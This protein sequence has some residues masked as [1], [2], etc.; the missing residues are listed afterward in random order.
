MITL[1]IILMIAFSVYVGYVTFSAYCLPFGKPHTPSIS[2]PVKS[3]QILKAKFVRLT[4]KAIIRWEQLR[5][6]SFSLLDYADR[7]DIEA[8]LYTMYCSEAR[9]EYTFDVFRLVL[10]DERFMNAISSDLGRI[11]EIVAQFQKKDTSDNGN[12]KGEY[13]PV[14]VSEI[15]STLIMSGLDAGYALNEMELCDLP[16]YIEAYKRQKKERME[17]SRMWAYLSMLPHIDAKKMKNGAKDL[18]AFPWE[19]EEM[20]KE[21]QRALDED[22]SRF[23]EFMNQ[24]KNLIK[25]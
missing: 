4:M 23:E 17:E 22:A 20:L 6:K 25:S 21:A 1:I 14:K 9:P 10:E 19:E 5:D 8:L 18:V 16:M 11:M 12:A 15:I 2:C 13:N 3:K 24:G 7:E